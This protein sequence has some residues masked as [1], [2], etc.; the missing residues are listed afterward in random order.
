MTEDKQLCKDTL[1]D[2][3]GTWGMKWEEIPDIG[4]YMDQVIGLLKRQLSYRGKPR[5]EEVI[6]SSMVNNY[7]KLGYMP[8]P[9][10]KRY[11]R[12][13][14]AVLYMLCSLKSVLPIASASYLLSGL[15]DGFESEKLKTLYNHFIAEQRKNAEETI[16]AIPEWEKEGNP[17]SSAFK[18]SVKA[19]STELL[20]TYFLA[21]AGESE[22]PPKES[23]K[24][25]QAEETARRLQENKF[26]M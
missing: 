26:D 14:V 5:G 1:T 9:E 17:L 15:T 21:E 3:F 11:S 13:Q 4:L 19:A 22:T 16:Q 6:T 10:N 20:A 7:V 23:K 8:R 12:N 24:K 2:Y 18:L 25:K